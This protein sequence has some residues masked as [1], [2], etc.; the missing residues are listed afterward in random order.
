MLGQVGWAGALLYNETTNR[1]IDGHL[2]QEVVPEGELVPVLIGSWTP[3]QEALIL[4]TLDPL[5]AMAEADASKVQ[6]LLDGLGEQDAAV[7]A[8]LDSLAAEAGIVAEVATVDAEA[9]TDKAEE[10]RQHWG[11]ELGQLWQLGEHRLLCGDSTRREDVERVMQGAKADMIFTDPPYGVQY[12]GVGGNSIAGDI[13]YTAIPLFFALLPVVLDEGWLYIC[14]GCT[15]ES[16]YSRMFEHYLRMT[17]RMIV[18]DKGAMTMRHNGYHSC[19]ELIF[20]GY[21]GG[22]GDWWF[23]DRAGEK[24]TDIW[25]V[26]KPTNDK[27]QHLTEKPIELPV[28]AI[29]NTCPPSGIVYE[30]FTGSG[31]TLLACHNLGRKCIGIEIAPGYVA[32][33]LE[34][35]LQATGIEPRLVET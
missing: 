33:T 23:S 14:G 29:S 3:E 7:Q 15:N 35:F 32:V 18:W 19:Y 8:V 24:A 6:A 26:A 16:L 20:F 13:T 34:R 12:Q 25:R 31:S 10:L 21:A 2:R 5:A 30:P 11:T 28:R 4:A 22:A 17:P 9:Q 27:R 1:L